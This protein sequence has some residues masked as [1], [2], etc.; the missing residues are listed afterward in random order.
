MPQGML[1]LIL[2]TFSTHPQFPSVVDNSAVRKHP[3]RGLSLQKNNSV[4][5]VLFQS[6]HILIY[7]CL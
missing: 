1:I 5:C 2:I 3:E 6:Q 7:C 4:V